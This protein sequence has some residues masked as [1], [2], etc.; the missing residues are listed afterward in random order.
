MFPDNS[1][2][3]YY[4]RGKKKV[5]KRRTTIIIL[6]HKQSFHPAKK[7]L[8]ETVATFLLQVDLKDTHRITFLKIIRIH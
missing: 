6:I 5:E 2:I 7:S 3:L 8:N 1:T 4:T